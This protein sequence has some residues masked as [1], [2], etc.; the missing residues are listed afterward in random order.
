MNGD[1]HIMHVCIELRQIYTDFAINYTD[2][3]YIC[4]DIENMVWQYSCCILRKKIELGGY[5]NCFPIM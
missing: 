4:N 5:C 2:I 1:S 3:E